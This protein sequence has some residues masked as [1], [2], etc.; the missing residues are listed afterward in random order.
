MYFL[1]VSLDVRIMSQVQN[2]EMAIG[3]FVILRG[4]LGVV[5]AGFGPF[6][7]CLGKTAPAL[8]DSWYSATP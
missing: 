1:A 4:L 7:A 8:D 6:P 5:A 2:E 3:R